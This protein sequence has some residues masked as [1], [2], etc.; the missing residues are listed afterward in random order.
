MNYWCPDCD[1][2]DW[3]FGTGSRLFE[4]SAVDW[5]SDVRKPEKKPDTVVQSAFDWPLIDRGF[6]KD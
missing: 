3:F 4:K 1:S 6:V 2:H 5:E